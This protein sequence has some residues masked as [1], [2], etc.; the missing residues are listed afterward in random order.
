MILQRLLCTMNESKFACVHI[1]RSINNILFINNIAA[2]IYGR[3]KHK[4]KKKKIGFQFLNVSG[5]M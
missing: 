3:F 4:K 1:S 2:L 5:D